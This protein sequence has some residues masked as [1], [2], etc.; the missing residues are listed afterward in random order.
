MVCEWFSHSC[1]WTFPRSNPRYSYETSDQIDEE[2]RPDQT[3][4]LPRTQSS[5]THWQGYV[6]GDAI[7]SPS[8]YPCQSVGEW[9]SDWLLVSDL[10]IAI[11]SPSL[12][13]IK[14]INGLCYATKLTQLPH[15]SLFVQKIQIQML[16]RQ[17]ANPNT[18]PATREAGPAWVESYFATH[19]HICKR[20]IMIFFILENRSQ[21]IRFL[22]EE[23]NLGSWMYDSG[24]GTSVIR[25]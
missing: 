8:T 17:H 5:T 25:S 22:N 9:V 19:E 7:A 13:F 24:G 6:L 15:L 2:T 20:K 11:A 23:V 12:F 16:T 3:T 18:A 10:E 21:H 14:F 4:F 1:C